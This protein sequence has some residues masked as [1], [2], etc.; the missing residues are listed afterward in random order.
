MRSLSRRAA[1]R[2]VSALAATAAPTIVSAPAPRVCAGPRRSARSISFT[3]ARSPPLMSAPP[4]SASSVPRAASAG[5]PPTSS[6]ALL[7]SRGAAGRRRSAAG[8][9]RADARA[10]APT[11]CHSS[12]SRAG[13]VLRARCRGALVERSSPLRA[14]RD[15]ARPRA[16]RPP[17]GARRAPCGARS[18]APTRAG[19]AGAQPRVGAHRR[20]ERLLEAV[21]GLG[22]ADRA[23]RKR[24]TSSRCCVEEALE[25][26]RLAGA[27]SR[28]RST[29][30]PAPREREVAACRL[31]A[32]AAGRRGSRRQSSRRSPPR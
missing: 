32:I 4:F 30:T 18:S 14:P 16:R 12:S 2:A 22:R 24:Q 17:R 21:V 9:P 8:P 10:A 19:S 15:R 13:A 26:G 6:P 25:G 31:R 27:A 29:G 28:S 3:V 11:A 20:D 5:P 1:A 7:R 23:T